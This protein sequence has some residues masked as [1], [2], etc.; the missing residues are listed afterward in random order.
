[1]SKIR[2]NRR[3]A[4][5]A[6]TLAILT[7]SP[8]LVAGCKPAPAANPA[9]QP[10]EVGVITVRPTPVRRTTELPGRTT[11]AM[12]SDVRPQITGV[13]LRRLFD[14]GGEVKEGQQ[15]Y[16]IDPR[17]YKAALDQAMA[18]RAQD[19]AQLETAQLDLSRYQQQAVREFAPRQQVDQQRATV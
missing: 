5:R 11:A 6:A 15:L 17:P 13:I 14:E 8:L 10:A 2:S 12:N 7:L 4:G 18:Q 9:P 19:Q 16:E 1:M 3:G